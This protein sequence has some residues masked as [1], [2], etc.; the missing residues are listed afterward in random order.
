MIAKVNGR[1]VEVLLMQVPNMRL[2]I[3]MYCYVFITVTVSRKYS[4]YTAIGD[5]VLFEYIV[6]GCCFIKKFHD[7][8][9]STKEIIHFGCVVGDVYPLTLR[10]NSR[11]IGTICFIT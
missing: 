8:F 11:Q 9:D 5:T 3:L 7:F 2:L 6:L 10:R 1:E 4:I